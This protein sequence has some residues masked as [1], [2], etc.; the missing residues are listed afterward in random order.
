MTQRP[1]LSGS[2]EG[3]GVAKR[4]WY[5]PP[6]EV[7]EHFG[8][9]LHFK[10]NATLADRDEIEKA[11]N[12]WLM[13]GGLGLCARRGFGGFHDVSNGAPTTQAQFEARLEL[14]LPAGQL[15]PLQLFPIF[16]FQSWIRLRWFHKGTLA[17]DALLC[18]ANEIQNISKIHKVASGSRIIVSGVPRANQ[19]MNADE[20]FSDQVDC[21]LRQPGPIHIHVAPL[22]DATLVMFANLPV[23]AG[24]DGRAERRITEFFKSPEFA[25]PIW[26]PPPPAP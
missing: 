16:S 1:P 17:Q 2:L 14:S 8:L 3:H 19:P 11:L 23:T 10:R 9:S 20:F 12:L 25:Q 7:T 22:A 15:P 24:A 26:L 18:I 6:Q 13:F 4:Q 21:G 5:I